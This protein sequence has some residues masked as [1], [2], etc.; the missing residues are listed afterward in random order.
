MNILNKEVHTEEYITVLVILSIALLISLVVLLY[1]LSEDLLIQ[2]ILALAG[3]VLSGMI[4]ANKL[5]E[6][7]TVQ[8]NA[9]VTDIKEVKDRGY[10][11][12]EQD[13]EMFILEKENKE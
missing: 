8:Y 13:E 4:I 10:K 11:I 5:E 2:G 1:S 12:I 6:G 7:A 9:T 3:L